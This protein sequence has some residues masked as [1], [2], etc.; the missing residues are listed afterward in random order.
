MIL[1]NY[2]VSSPLFFAPHT[3]GASPVTGPLVV[4]GVLTD[5]DHE[6]GPQHR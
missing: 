2:G 3:E 4:G 6:V 1:K 5:G